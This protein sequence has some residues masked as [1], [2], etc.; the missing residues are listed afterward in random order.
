MIVVWYVFQI[1]SWQAYSWVNCCC[2]LFWV[3]LFCFFWVSSNLAVGLFEFPLSRSRYKSVIWFPSYMKPLKP[4][5]ISTIRKHT[6]MN[7]NSRLDSD[8]YKCLNSWVWYHLGFTIYNAMYLGVE[9]ISSHQIIEY[10]ISK[11]NLNLNFLN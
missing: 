10:W 1:P 9:L 2:L 6:R 4:F 3:V 8:S 5:C 7:R 11:L